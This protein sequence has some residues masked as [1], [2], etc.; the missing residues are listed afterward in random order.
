M[1]LQRKKRKTV[2][3]II[4]RILAAAVLLLIA[5]SVILN[6]RYKTRMKNMTLEQRLQYNLDQITDGKKIHG[7]VFHIYRASDG[8]SWSGSTGHMNTDSQ[9]PIASITKMYTAAVL[10]M[11]EQEGLIDLDAGITEYLPP[12]LTDRLHNYRGQDYSSSITVR[13]LMSHQSG[14]PDYFTE[15]VTEYETKK[16]SVDEMIAIDENWHYDIDKVVEWT[17]I[18]PAHFAPGTN[19][20][21]Y[22]SDAN[23]QL[24]G[25][26]IEQIT[27]QSLSEVYTE[28]IFTPLKLTKTYLQTS[29][30]EWN[31]PPVTRHNKELKPASVLASEGPTGAIISTAEE[32]MIFLRAFWGG[33]LF[34]KGHLDSMQEWN[35]IF[36]PMEYGLGIMR[37]KAP[38]FVVGLSGTELT[39]HSGSTGSAS[40]Y[41]PAQD[42]Y[43]VGTT[44]S[45]DNP[46]TAIQ[47]ALGLLASFNYDQ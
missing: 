24:L 29:Q 20:K 47:L 19:D 41:C 28:R 30:N 43:I 26:I 32:S 1:G 45:M 10:I 16:I 21:A 27:G 8:F 4:L 6:Q 34:D 36:Y 9:Y 23:Y 46:A 15:P 11:M 33:E 17:R 40:F 7:T 3:I 37:F 22:Y 2:L 5:I 44:N 42:I 38:V 12:R 13:H 25:Q 35:K 18:R 31:M 39:G 14:L